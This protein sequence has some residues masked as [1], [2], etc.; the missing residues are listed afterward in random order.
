LTDPIAGKWL[1]VVP[2]QEDFQFHN[3]QYETDLRF[4]LLL[5]N[6][7]AVEGTNCDGCTRKVVLDPTCH[8]LVSGCPCF[9][10]RT[11]LH[12]ALSY[13]ANEMAKYCGFRTKREELH[14]F[15]EADP[16]CGKKPDVSIFNPPILD[17]LLGIGD[18]RIR[19]LVLDFQVTDPLPGSASGV[20]K[21]M[22]QYLAEKANHMADM[23]FATKNRKYL[24]IAT[25]NGLSFLPIIFESTGRIHPKSLKFFEAIADHAAEVKKINKGIVFAFIM[26]KL[27]CV[28]QKNLASNINSRLDTI[29]GHQTRAVSRHY[30]LSNASVSTHERFRSRGHGLG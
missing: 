2:K 12:D 17:N 13:A 29:N 26:N 7:F 1:T 10:K 19:K 3:S 21:P 4:R 16:E 5:P 11:Q 23:A 9:G 20:F 22:S 8:H 28:F 30:S 15:R 25:E 14:C 18:G 27:S 6:R 24:N